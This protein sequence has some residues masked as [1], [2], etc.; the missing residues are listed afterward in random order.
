MENAHAGYIMYHALV[1]TY[2]S[3]PEISELV[4]VAELA[5]KYQ[6]VDSWKEMK[7]LEELFS[8]VVMDAEHC[9]ASGMLSGISIDMCAKNIN[10]ILQ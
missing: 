2:R 4:S 1:E 6:L 8:A 5:I 7:L 3:F 9:T 10:K